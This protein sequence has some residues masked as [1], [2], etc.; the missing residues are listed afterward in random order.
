MLQTSFHPAN[1]GFKDAL[2]RLIGNVIREMVHQGSLDSFFECNF[3]R[4]T[5]STSFPDAFAQRVMNC[6]T[7]THSVSNFVKTRMVDTVDD[8][9][10]VAKEEP[11]QAAVKLDAS[12][13]PS[14]LDSTLGDDYR[15]PAQ[16]RK[17][18]AKRN[19]NRSITPSRA[20]KDKRS[21][22]TSPPGGKF[23]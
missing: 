2:F 16:K 4:T 10:F 19:D 8:W 20:K 12:V 14:L 11:A 18:R 1:D 23:V 21:D 6:K 15:V 22:A 13:P 3:D 17:G 9:H 7:L 5:Q